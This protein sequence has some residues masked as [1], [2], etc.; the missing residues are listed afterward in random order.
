MRHRIGLAVVSLHISAGV[1]LL[2]AVLVFPLALREGGEGLV[3]AEA[4][5][6]DDQGES[7]EGGGN[8]AG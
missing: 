8:G 1:Y 3:A 7:E 2:L 4:G 6:D 5:R